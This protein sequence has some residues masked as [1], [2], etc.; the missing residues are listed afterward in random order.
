VTPRGDGPL[1]TFLVLALLALAA[2]A[3]GVAGVV[4]ARKPGP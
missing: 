3:A 2:G 1:V 4:R